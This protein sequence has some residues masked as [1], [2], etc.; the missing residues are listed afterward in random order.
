M[1]LAIRIPHW[2]KLFVSGR[3]NVLK[4]GCNEGKGRL[5][6]LRNDCGIMK[7]MLR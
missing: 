4:H 7:P 2:L 5:V 3:G 1:L 6:L